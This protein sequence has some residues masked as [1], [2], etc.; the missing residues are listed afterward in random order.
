M[1]WERRCDCDCEMLLRARVG[2]IRCLGLLIFFSAAKGVDLVCVGD[3]MGDG[4]V[5]MRRMVVV[6]RGW[7]EVE[8]MEDRREMSVL[9]IKKAFDTVFWSRR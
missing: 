8:R 3:G 6:E 7:I 5:G 9:R 4:R 1:V 2:D